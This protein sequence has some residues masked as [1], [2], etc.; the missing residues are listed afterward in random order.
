MGS[1]EQARSLGMVLVLA[2]VVWCRTVML[3]VSLPEWL[4]LLKC[5][6]LGKVVLDHAA[7]AIAAKAPPSWRRISRSRSAIKGR[8]GCLGACCSPL[9]LRCASP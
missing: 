5:R 9:Y 3:R 6:A 2:R 4:L 7:A 8:V 1:R